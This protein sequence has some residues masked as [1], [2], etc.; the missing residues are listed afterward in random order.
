MHY[1]KTSFGKSS[2]LV[3]MQ[4]KDP[5]FSDVIGNMKTAHPNDYEKINRI[6]GCNASKSSW[7]SWLKPW[8]WSWPW[9]SKD[10][11]VAGHTC[12]AKPATPC[13]DDP[14]APCAQVAGKCQ[15]YPAW[16]VYCRKTCNTCVA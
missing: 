15:Q 7:T 10:K 13:K 16:S 11:T 3:T 8:E 12:R 6:Y 2:G 9:Q 14:T 4:T 5:R 1:D